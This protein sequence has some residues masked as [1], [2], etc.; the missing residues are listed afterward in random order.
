[1]NISILSFQEM[2]KKFIRLQEKYEKLERKMAEKTK[3][4]ESNSYMPTS[5][6][7]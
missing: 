6:S 5:V 1:M 3:G 7:P 2:G 4:F